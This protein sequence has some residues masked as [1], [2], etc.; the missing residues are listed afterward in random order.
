MKS[1]LVLILI[2]FS[3]LSF[4]QSFFK[5]YAVDTSRTERK[6]NIHLVK[7]NL[8]STMY[9]LSGEGLNPYSELVI[10]QLDVN[11]G[12]M[13]SRVKFPKEYSF[14]THRS[15][16]SDNSILG[17][18]W[19]S[20]PGGFSSENVGVYKVSDDN[21]LQLFY[22]IGDSTHREIPRDITV[23]QSGEIVIGSS[24]LFES[25]ASYTAKG[26]VTKTSSEGDFIWE[27]IDDIPSARTEM[28]SVITDVANNIYVLSTQ[29]GIQDSVRL[30]KLTP[31]GAKLWTRTYQEGF[32]SK[33]QQI[34]NLQNGNMLIAG[35]AFYDK[36]G[37]AS[38]NFYM[39]IDTSGNA[40]W[41]DDYKPYIGGVAYESEIKILADGR[42]ARV[43]DGYG[44]PTLMVNHP[45]G[46]VDFIKHYDEL[47][48]R[49][50]DDLLQLDDGSFIIVGWINPNLNT[51]GY[52]SWMMRTDT[53]G[54]LITSTEEI[55]NEF[56]TLSV[57]PNPTKS[58]LNL[59]FDKN[60]YDQVVIYDLLGNEIQHLKPMKQIDVSSY[61][62][63]IYI[64]WLIGDTGNV[65]SRKFVKQ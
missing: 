41:V 27:Y 32:L 36:Y 15:I 55:V 57:Y 8:Y 2:C 24:R 46:E 64:V 4:G 52:T 16:V 45:G 48:V 18:G 51:E 60:L 6:Y 10:D 65:S 53:E 26:I 54:N 31:E 1:Q 56:N 33:A 14:V 63:G 9:H 22:E 43:Y 35:Y 37:G 13:I 59:E 42:I 62:S 3:T 44:Y 50:P 7:G 25:G 5:K 30:T 21:E 23:C 58:I 28:R 20:K 11:S 61:N 40:I 34:L 39:E 19:Y 47:D 17:V 38:S 49:F 29:D 12:D